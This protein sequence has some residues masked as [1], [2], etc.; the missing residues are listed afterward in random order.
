M[1]P[2]AK[3]DF[4]RQRQ[5]R[6]ESENNLTFH[7]WNIDG[8]GWQLIGNSLRALRFL[9]KKYKTAAMRSDS[10]GAPRKGFDAPRIAEG[11]MGC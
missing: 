11:E 9:I 3:I 1:T 10:S 8:N 7:E 2:R 6:V 5:N 4:S